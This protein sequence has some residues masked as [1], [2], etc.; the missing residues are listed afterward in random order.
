[1]NFFDII[2]CI[3]LIWGIYKGFTKGLIIEVAG[4]AAFFLGIWAATKFSESLKSLFSFAGKYDGVVAF[5][6]L[7]L[8]AIILIFLI[9]KLINKIVEG[10]ALSSVN[11]IVGAAF[12]GLK[13][14]LILSVLFFVLDAIEKSYPMLSVKTKEES[15]L[16]KPV[17]IIAPTVIPGLDKNK[18]ETMMP[19]AEVSLNSIEKVNNG[20][21]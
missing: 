12:G 21:K 2:I 10:A 16:Y 15:L 9:A 3:P 17:S 20:R 4:L 5:C 13:F 11:K 18:M 14:A 19:R 1:M 7:F 6:L 8:A